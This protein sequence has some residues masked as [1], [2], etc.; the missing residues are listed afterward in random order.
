MSCR[1]GHKTKRTRL[2]E[3]E[4]FKVGYCNDWTG[5]TH[6]YL[7]VDETIS[8]RYVVRQFVE[9]HDRWGRGFLAG[10]SLEIKD[11]SEVTDIHEETLEGERV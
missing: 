7:I 3:V 10:S 5:A 11:K 6:K 1:L 4:R 9:H 2:K 8:G